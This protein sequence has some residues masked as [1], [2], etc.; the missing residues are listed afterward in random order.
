MLTSNAN[1]MSPNKAAFF[2][3]LW[4]PSSCAE[5]KVAQKLCNGVSGVERLVWITKKQKTG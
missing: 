3:I 5:D 1:S 4:K 2:R